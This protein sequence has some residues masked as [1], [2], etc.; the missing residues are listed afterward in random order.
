MTTTIKDLLDPKQIEAI[1]TKVSEVFVT[2]GMDILGGIVILILG[3]L[4]ARWAQRSVQKLLN[5]THKID[6]T[7][8]PLIASIVRYAILILVIIAVL[9]QFGVETT[10]LIAVLG[11]AGLAIG[12][13]LQGTLSNIAAGVML[14]ILRPMRIGEY[15][16]A[17]G[18]EGTVEEIGL[19]TSRLKKVDGV[20]VS[21]P[22]S[23]IWGKAITN[24][25]RNAT[26]RFDL[27]VGIGYDDNM[28]DALKV[29]KKLAKDKRILKDPAPET[30]ITSLGDS[31]VNTNL[32][33]WCKT[34]D[35]WPLRFDLTKKVKEE[36]DKANI[37]IPF[38]QRD[39][40]VHEV[41]KK[42]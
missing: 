38:P 10:S 1:T 35:Y 26:R 27:T 36:F 2:F 14:L 6:A 9:G 30:M 21:V 18:T 19:F 41:K 5:K 40:H 17:E 15:I 7:L 20:F 28:D 4:I 11:A 25:S 8:K 23:Q 12:L 3:W 37:S 34:D 13:A 39:V 42:G 33:V 16:N 22:N 29:L 31:A 24:F 32:R